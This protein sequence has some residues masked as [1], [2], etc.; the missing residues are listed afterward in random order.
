[1]PRCHRTLKCPKP[2]RK[3]YP[4]EPRALGEY[5]KCRRLD[6][7][8][9]QRDVAREI[10]VNAETVGHWELGRSYPPV[11]LIPRIHAFLGFCPYDPDWTFG[12][13]LRAAREAQGL[14]RRRVAALVGLDEG[15]VARL[16][17]GV[18]RMAR[19]SHRA[20]EKLLRTHG[21]RPGAVRERNRTTS[22][23][24]RRV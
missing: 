22:L 6:L 9:R 21:K 10:G 24:P 2:Q 3:D 1:L 8:L 20:I 4:E 11:R 12:G 18:P 13:R 5:L 23:P 7:G 19:R 14:S 15:T 16:E 17:Q